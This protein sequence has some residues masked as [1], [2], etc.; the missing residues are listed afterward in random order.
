M[1]RCLDFKDD[2][3]IHVYPNLKYVATELWQVNISL[4]TYFC[5]RVPFPK[6]LNLCY[7]CQVK[8]GTL[9]DNVLVCDDPEYAKSLAEET[10]GKLKDVCSF[11]TAS[12]FPH[13]LDLFFFNQQFHLASLILRLRRQHL[14]R[15]RKRKRRYGAL[16]FYA[17]YFL[18]LIFFLW[19]TGV[20]KLI[21]TY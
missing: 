1:S 13:L 17:F 2:Q 11:F 10:W 15:R 14:R 4:H 20:V 18:S 9:F 16:A 3:D 19:L 21:L 5:S 8:S 6:T 7:L 12:F